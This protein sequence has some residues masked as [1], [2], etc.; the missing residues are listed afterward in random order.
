MIRMWR[1][2]E[3]GPPSQA[4]VMVTGAMPVRRSGEVLIRVAAAGL[5]FPD[6]LYCTGEYQ[7]RPPLPF[8]PGLEVCGVV[9]D[10]DPGHDLVIGER[11]VAFTEP[12]RGGFAEAVV[13]SASDVFPIPDSLDDARAAGM[14]V[15]Y[16][17]AHLGLCRRA[18]LR[19]R[20]TLLVHGA[21]GGVGSAALQV[22]KALG[23]LVIATAGDASKA[24]RCRD[25]GADLVIDRSVEDFVEIVRDVT[26]GRGADVVFDPIG[27]DVFEESRRCVA[28]EGRYLI[29][30]FAGGGIPS[31]PAGHIL[32]KNYSVLGLHMSLYRN[33]APETIA[34]AHKELMTMW[35]QG[36]IAPAVSEIVAFEA[37]PAA[38][39]QLAA[40]KSWG[41][42]VA[43]IWDAESAR[44]SYITH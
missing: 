31:L 9:E 19:A 29:I 41:K 18:G 22:G 1:A 27:A 39:E 8:T 32:V 38:L 44:A 17:T 37:I 42:L 24:S 26:S 11:V 20:E 40:R 15:T 34:T 5:N 10:I 16:Q 35:R 4:L 30:G 25:L 6:V 2:Q 33:M 28:F 23:A 43:H 21:A 36:K 13:A 14:F 7:D 12:P 3:Y